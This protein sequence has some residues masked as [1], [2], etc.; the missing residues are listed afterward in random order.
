MVR[1][2]CWHYEGKSF[3][4]A[5]GD[6]SLS[7]WNVKKGNGPKDEPATAWAPHSRSNAMERPEATAAAPRE[8]CRPI[9][10]VNSA[11]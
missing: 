8:R 4:V 9:P 5:H 2:I 3:V 6:G 10:Q 1:D 7:I 11:L